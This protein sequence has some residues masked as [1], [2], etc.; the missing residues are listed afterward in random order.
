MKNIF[1]LKSGLLFLL[2]AGLPILGLVGGLATEFILLDLNK[3]AP[4]H[5]SEIGANIFM[6]SWLIGFIVF[7]L[8]ALIA[9][10]SL[11]SKGHSLKVKKWAMLTFGLLS[12]LVLLYVSIE[13]LYPVS[14]THLTLPTK[15]IV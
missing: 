5:D 3:G 13:S 4:F 9:G 10:I 8:W 1:N 14:Y 12:L 15:R 7:H 6:G 11:S 2:T